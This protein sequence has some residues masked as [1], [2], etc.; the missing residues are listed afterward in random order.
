MDQHWISTWIMLLGLKLTCPVQAEKKHNLLGNQQQRYQ[1]NPK[2]C[3]IY[4][5]IGSMIIK[6]PRRNAWF[7]QFAKKP[8][9]SMISQGAF[10]C[11]CYLCS[12]SWKLC[13]CKS[14]KSTVRDYLEHRHWWFSL[15]HWC[16]CMTPHR[17]GKLLNE[18]QTLK[19][20][21]H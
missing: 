21:F 15:Q 8:M 19:Q 12:W 16:M 3:S 1:P 17:K 13:H 7:Q 6:K 10:G 9:I 20:E 2:L 11:G 14:R 18:A 4:I 5:I